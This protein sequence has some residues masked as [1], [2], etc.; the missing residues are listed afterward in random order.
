MDRLKGEIN[1]KRNEVNS[2]NTRLNNKCP[3]LNE[4]DEYKSLVKE[5]EDL[6]LNRLDI[7][8]PSQD[9][10]K[11]ASRLYNRIK[12]NTRKRISNSLII[13]GLLVLTISI[14]GVI[15][16]FSNKSVALGGIVSSLIGVLLFIIGFIIKDG[17]HDMMRLQAI[18]GSFK[19]YKESLDE[20]MYILKGLSLDKTKERI[21]ELEGRLN[22]YFKSFRLN[23]SSYNDKI[24]EL[25]DLV[26]NKKI[27]TDDV[28]NKIAEYN[29]YL[30]LN[31]TC[32]SILDIASINKEIDEIDN[33]ASGLLKDL[34]VLK[35]EL[36]R[37]NEIEDL[38][39]V[40][41][42]KRE[43]LNIHLRELSDELRILNL[44]R[45]LLIKSN[46]KML[47]TYLRPMKE[48]LD[49]YLA[50]VKEID[51]YEID[52]S[53]NLSINT[54]NG[55]KSASLLS[56]GQRGLIYFLMRLSLIDILYDKEYPFI[57]LDDPFV[58]LDDNN[59][60]L[61]LELLKRISR[62]K[63]LIYFTCKR[64]RCVN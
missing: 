52:T 45:E 11:E 64:E 48:S 3:G 20:G 56:K 12:N 21:S 43:E 28:N 24:I 51:K 44:S 13:M 62:D 50:L 63:Q 58:S 23:G 35:K 17:S 36:S 16:L 4:I 15:L 25:E 59:L 19:I 7:K 54:P 55:D 53:F 57:I 46:E 18:L 14:C 26:R 60:S 22:S 33:K 38:I 2:I 5:Y 32:D 9:D 37:A 10:V 34:G 8:R 49:R 29:S 1:S 39:E 61:A 27:I 6:S 47:N 41:E 31:N 30:S 42:S 40:N